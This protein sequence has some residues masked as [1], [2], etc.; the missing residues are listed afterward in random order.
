MVPMAPPIRTQLPFEGSPAIL[1]AAWD[2]HKGHNGRTDVSNARKWA[3]PPLREYDPMIINVALTGAVPTKEDSPHVPMTPS[4]IAADAL[5]CAREG[6]SIVHLH[7]RD[8]SGRPTQ[9]VSLYSETIAA[10]RK[11][12][13]DLVVCASTS[14]RVDPRPE[15]RVAPLR[16]PPAVRPDMASLTLG[17]FN[18]P[19]GPSVNPPGEIVEILEEMRVNGVK[20]ELEIFEPGMVN[21][22]HSLIEKGLIGSPPYFNILLGSMGT[23]PASM[24]MLAF[25]V[26]RLPDD[27]LWAGAG[28]GMFQRPMTIAAAVM[29]GHVRTGLEDAPRSS[30]GA[31]SSN[32]AAV[33][34]AVEA[35]RLC[36]RPVATPGETRRTL[37]LGRVALS[38]AEV[39]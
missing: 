1:A 2:H 13:P 32:V 12:A 16:L 15:A 35:A 39:P 8:E 36:E 6:A 31:P 24:G 25:I 20:P 7:M 38:E 17:S 11:E 23:A 3:P 29:G 37:G 28:I 26:D 27:A 5:A 30:T 9:D 10:I 33:R 21:T 34:V 22:A 4:E 14:S 18:F 19:N